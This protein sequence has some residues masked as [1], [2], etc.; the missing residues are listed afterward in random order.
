MIVISFFVKRKLIDHSPSPPLV[1]HF[2]DFVEAGLVVHVGYTFIFVF[3]NK[4]ADTCLKT[5][6]HNDKII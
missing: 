2:S 3:S 4:Y 5:V 6:K 1:N